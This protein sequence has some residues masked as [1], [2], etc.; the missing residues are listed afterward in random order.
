MSNCKKNPRHTG[1]F[2][3]KRFSKI[4]LPH[5][6]QEEIFYYYIQSLITLTGKIKTNYTSPD[7]SQFYPTTG[8]PIKASGTGTIAS[9]SEIKDND[10]CPCP[11]CKRS[12]IQ[13][14]IFYLI[15]VRTTKHMIFN[16]KEAQQSC[17]QIMFDEETSPEVNLY[18]L[19]LIE[20][21]IND[22]RSLVMYVTHDLQIGSTLA[23]TLRQLY[24]LD[25]KIVAKHERSY[26]H[27]L[28]V[29]ISHPHGS[30]KR[31]S[32]G[33]W[34]KRKFV[35]SSQDH[36]YTQYTYNTATC[37]G[38]AGAPVS[39]LGERI[40]RVTKCLLTPHV[41][42]ETGYDCSTSCYGIESYRI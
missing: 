39:I 28:A 41:H 26:D 35:F 13:K 31:V 32:I 2:E 3:V 22:E 1:Y 7:R 4:N 17:F 19:R 5:G 33:K 30:Y 11:E 6:Y 40:P 21:E 34:L 24:T 14:K 23:S 37:Q 10:A 18:G 9:V 36:V 16:D 8:G 15:F 42:K 38:C 27:K 20:S 12:V 29:I 25:K